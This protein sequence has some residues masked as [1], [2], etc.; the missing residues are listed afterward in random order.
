MN[1]ILIGVGIVLLLVGL[2]A[3][4][5]TVTSVDKESSAFGLQKSTDTNIFAPYAN[6]ALPLIVIGAAIL[7]IGALVYR[8]T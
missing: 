8:N 1:R 2:V 5:Y 6:F 3:E 4:F 7:V